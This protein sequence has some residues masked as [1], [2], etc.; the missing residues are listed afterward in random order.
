MKP[1]VL[2]VDDDRKTV[3]LIRIYL[4]RDGY[5]VLCAYDG[6][7]ALELARSARPG[8]IILDLMLPGGWAGYFAAF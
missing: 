7:K 8:L 3:D 6:M 2:V 5:R 4:E 1:A